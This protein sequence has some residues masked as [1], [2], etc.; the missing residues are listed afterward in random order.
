[1]PSAISLEKA[2]FYSASLYYLASPLKLF[3]P[4]VLN[5]TLDFVVGIVTLVEV[6]KVCELSESPDQ[7]SGLGAIQ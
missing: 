5:L 3:N 1:M 2:R 6:L 4:N 7:L